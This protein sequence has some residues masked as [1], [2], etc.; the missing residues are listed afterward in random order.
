[1]A[2]GEETQ[3]DWNQG[4][5]ETPFSKIINNYIQDSS[6]PLVFYDEDDNVLPNMTLKRAEQTGRQALIERSRAKQRTHNDQMLTRVP[7]KFNQWVRTKAS[8]EIRELI[9]QA[10]NHE[11][12]AHINPQFDGATLRVRGMSDTFYGVKDFAVYKHNRA[13]AEKLVWGGRGANCHDVGAGKTLSSIITSQV[14]L[15]QGACNKPMFVVPGKVQEKWVEE[16]AML[17]PEAK[18]LNMKMTGSERHKELTMAQLYGWDAIF[19]ADHAFKSLPLSPA[20]QQQMYSER[21]EYFDQ[22]IDSF[23]ELIEEDDALSSTAKKSMVTRLEKMKE[24]WEAKLRGAASAKRLDTDIFFD[25]L[26]VDALFFD[27]AHFYKNALGSAKASKLGIAASKPSQ[28]AEDALQK[29]KWLFS[30]VGYRNVFVLTATPVV[31]SPVEVW[32]MLNLCAP[33]LLE[34]YQIA[35]LDNFINQFVREEDK[36]VKKTNGEYRT[37]RVV[38]G[39]YNLPEMRAIIDEVMDIK[40][41]DQLVGFYEK[42]PDYLRDESGEIVTD[43]EDN[44]QTLK[45]KFKRPEA[46]TKQQ[47]IEPSEIHKLLFDDIILRANDILECMRRRGCETKDNFLVITGDGSK[48]AT[49]LRVYDSSFE[50]VDGKYLKLGA[51]TK[52]VAES[53][54]HRENPGPSYHP[55]SIYGD[56]FS[57]QQREARENPNPYGGQSRH[58]LIKQLKSLRY[59]E[60]VASKIE[61]TEGDLH[62]VPV[63]KQFLLNQIEKQ[64]EAHSDGSDKMDEQFDRALMIIE[65]L[66]SDRENPEPVALRNQIIFCDW[67]SIDSGKGGSY[68]QLIKQE[69]SAAGIPPEEI[70]II[71]GSIIGTDS[72]GNDYFVSTGDDKEALKK[73]VQDD[74]NQGKYRILIGNQSIAEGM[75]LQRWTTDL[76]HMDVPYTPSQI[77]QRNGRGLRQG[78]QYEKVRIHF[79]LMKDSFDQYRLELVSKK[80]S[81]IDELFFGDGRE[82]SADSKDES[83]QY[84]Q[85]VAATNSDPRVK[86]FFGAKAQTKVLK[87]RID[88]LL[89]ETQRLESSLGQA[90]QDI[91]SRT[92]RLQRA[93]SR[94]QAL[95]DSDLPETGQQAL[96]EKLISIGYLDYSGE[97]GTIEVNLTSDSKRIPRFRHQLALEVPKNNSNGRVL[98]NLVPDASQPSRNFYNKI[99]W[100]SIKQM[101]GA[102]LNELFGWSME[103][104]VQSGRSLAGNKGNGIADES[105]FYSYYGIDI[106]AE[107]AQ[108]NPDGSEVTFDQIKQ[109]LGMYSMDRWL[110]IIRLKLAG[111]FLALEKAWQASAQGRIEKIQAELEQSKKTMK[112]LERTHRQTQKELTEAQTTLTSNQD[113]VAKLQDVVNELVKTKFTDRSEL[114]EELNRIAPKYGV[115]RTVSVR[116]VGFDQPAPRKNPAGRTHPKTKTPALSD[117][118]LPL[119]LR[120]LYGQPLV[121]AGKVNE[122]EYVDGSG[123]MKRILADPDDLAM[124]IDAG[125]TMIFVFPTHRMKLVKGAFSSDPADQMFQEFHHFPAD[126]Y[127][128]ELFPPQGATLAEVGRAGRILYESD[129]VIYA[130]DQ[131]GDEHSYYHYFDEG[132]R[133]VFSY[134]DLLVITNLNI[135][136]RGILN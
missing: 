50:G 111:L 61:A 5:G 29:T 68:H 9:E 22:M 116:Q 87:A 90:S 18:I 52:K 91:E 27:E 79:Y 45:P 135:T 33:D 2:S 69:L 36:I 40:S 66:Y 105:D 130:G 84:E 14:L 30:K 10:Y 17:F 94:E 75:N 92:Q 41:Y 64:R 129:K 63:G 132:K 20:V 101:A 39:Y 58:K 62:E 82:T 48:I 37:E 98:F 26:G 126:G 131:K 11:Y 8:T 80:Q 73:Q 16:Y 77:Q 133:P 136:G 34:K 114:Y 99:K 21:V 121:Y 74:F 72:K 93:T 104:A 42:F 89:G 112:E 119:P 28:R 55:E 35:N 23:D 70:A 117:S 38:A 88:A 71:N 1:V 43:K 86:Q 81:W 108:S 124:I 59:F 83:L 97:I 54:A 6:F 44:P 106:E 25:E 102:Q 19:I 4:W 134:G 56:F 85:M 128:Y 122:L 109:Q 13:V 127:D 123:A 7:Q 49:D 107:K 47:V 24:E 100:S 78:N 53:Y 15:Q 120:V 46:E 3:D 96:D 113:T 125:G 67:I 60:E 32:H 12:N 115:R 31:N 76:H 51:L 95:M 57:K 118:K 110:P 65:A 103:E